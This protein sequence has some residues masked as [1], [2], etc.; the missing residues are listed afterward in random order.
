MPASCKQVGLTHAGLMCIAAG[1]IGPM[2][3]SYFAAQLRGT[4]Q[5]VESGRGAAFRQRTMAR[6]WPA[7]WL[8]VL[9]QPLERRFGLSEA[10][11]RPTRCQ[12]PAALQTAASRLQPTGTGEWL[13]LELVV[14]WDARSVQATFRSD[15]PGWL[16][17]LTAHFAAV[18]G[19]LLNTHFS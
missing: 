12:L 17:P 9:L 4:R 2:H 6:P 5:L 14:Y 1:A 16:L 18:L 8:S 15:A 7:R 13:M 11:R 10:P 19:Q 3:K